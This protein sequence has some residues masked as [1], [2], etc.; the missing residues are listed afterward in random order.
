MVRMMR[1]PRRPNGGE[2]MRHKGVHEENEGCEY[3]PKC[4]PVPD[5]G[6]ENP[7]LTEGQ[8]VKHLKSTIT[9][10][11]ADVVGET[12]RHY[13]VLKQGPGHD[14]F[15]VAKTDTSWVPYAPTPEVGDVWQYGEGGSRYRVLGVDERRGQWHICA[16][17]AFHNGKLPKI[18]DGVQDEDVRPII[19]TRTYP[20]VSDKWRLHERSEV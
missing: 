9:D 13:W 14:P 6:V 8:P 10:A 2:Y 12:A 11:V 7:T 18:P 5:R 17:D 3:D 4:V 16:V 20:D 19:F 15:T 1:A